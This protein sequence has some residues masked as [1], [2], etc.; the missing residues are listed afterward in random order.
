M[1]DRV[2]LNHSFSLR[3]PKPPRTLTYLRSTIISSFENQPLKPLAKSSGPKAEKWRTLALYLA[4][5]LIFIRFSDIHEAFFRRFGFN[6][7]PLYISGVPAILGMLASGGLRRCW[8]DRPTFYWVCFV[9]RMELAP[10]LNTW[11]GGSLPIVTTYY[12]THLI[13]LFVIGGRIVT[14]ESKHENS[15]WPKVRKHTR[16]F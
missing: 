16:R 15:S 6:F 7:Y 14:W 8:R 5:G 3:P 4:F 10:L 9:A 1:L 2:L 13:M 12:K 11:K